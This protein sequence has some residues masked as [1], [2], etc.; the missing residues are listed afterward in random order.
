MYNFQE[1]L[2][3]FSSPPTI[4]SSNNNNTKEKLWILTLQIFFPFLTAGL[5]M[6]AAGIVLDIVQHWP[7]F[8]EIN[9]IFIL[10]PALLGLKVNKR[11]FVYFLRYHSF[12]YYLFEFK[13]L[14]FILRL[15]FQ[16]YLENERE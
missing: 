12:F 7:V 6:V 2:L 16:S 15:R 10:V 14:L 5:G 8:V 1:N 13:E 9:E 11:F 3:K 4:N